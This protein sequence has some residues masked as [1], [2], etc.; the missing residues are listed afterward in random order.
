MGYV[1]LVTGASS[2][3]GKSIAFH[4][5]NLGHTVYGTSR[6]PKK[7]TEDFP[8]SLLSLDV[9]DAASIEALLI[10]LEKK[11]TKIDVLINN[12][13][14][15]ITGPVEET[16]LDAIRANFETNF[17]GP[18]AMIQGVLPLMRK[19]NNGII[20]NI[21]SIAG[22]MGLP[23]RGA[24]SASKGALNIISEALRLEIA[25]Q[26]IR[27]MTLAPGDYATDIASRRFHAPVIEGSPYQK[28]YQESLDT[29]DS[30]VDGGNDPIEIAHRVA[31][32]IHLKKPRPHYLV[33]PLLQK[34]SLTLKKILPQKAYEKLL[35]NHYKL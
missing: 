35:K 13:G 21:T 31:E 16:S 32:L 20:I 26:G 4:L 1:V 15:G 10:E 6:D 17:F 5:H 34:F 33:G 12:A 23:F 18:L 25:A 9:T 11:E 2:G 7:Y 8:F 30:H 22:Y 14:V 29:M 28:A 3:L 24:Y 27:L 19:N